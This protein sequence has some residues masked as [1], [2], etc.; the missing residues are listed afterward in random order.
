[1]C[2]MVRLAQVD[3]AAN[4]T[5]LMQNNK[6]EPVESHWPVCP[7]VAPIQKPRRSLRSTKEVIALQKEIPWG[8]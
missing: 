1:M 4:E 8:P 3:G 5:H 2:L 6:H 7:V